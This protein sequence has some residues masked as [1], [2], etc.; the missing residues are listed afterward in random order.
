MAQSLSNVLIH[1]V[2]STKDRSPSI[3]PSLQP[4]MHAY[5]SKRCQS[6][7]CFVFKVGGVEDHVHLLLFQE[8]YLKAHLLKRSRRALPSG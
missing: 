1:P 3:I 8:V 4:E 5:L 2:F 6:H 7:G